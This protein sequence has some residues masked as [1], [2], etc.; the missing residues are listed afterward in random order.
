MK[1]LKRI[2]NNF[3]HSFQSGMTMI[4]LLVVL[5]IF[6][7]VTSLVMFDYGSFR[8]STSLTNLASDISLSVRRAQSY[9]IGA[10]SSNSV[11]SYGYGVHFSTDRMPVSNQYNGSNK[12]FLLF[13]DVSGDKMYDSDGNP[14][15]SNV[16]S[17]N[18]CSEILTISSADEI[19]GIYLSGSS[20]ALP[21]GGVVDI[22]FLRPNPDAYFCYRS[23]PSSSSC[24]SSTG[25]SNVRVEISNYNEE[26]G[27]TKK[28]ITIWSTGQI[29]VQ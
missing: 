10:Y 22:M 2:I 17:T 6:I 4:E 28:D 21:V 19:S 7:V 5:G 9:A 24:D 8:S 3:H 1:N 12:S 18:E 16:S 11:F 29:S 20:T 27:F 15:S 25:I 26:V 23:S 14:C 13:T